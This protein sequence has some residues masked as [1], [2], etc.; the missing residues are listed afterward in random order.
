MRSGLRHLVTFLK[1]SG[2]WFFCQSWFAKLVHNNILGVVLPAIVGL[3]YLTLDVWGDKW[4]ILKDNLELHSRI[5][6]CVLVVTLC[7]LIWRAVA[8]MVRSARV[9][10][11]TRILERLLAVLGKIVKQKC[12][13]F[14]AKL[15]ELKPTTNPFDTITQPEEQIR[16]ILREA[17]HFFADMIGTQPEE[18]D[19]SV[20]RKDPYKDK[21]HFVAT[22]TTA[23]KPNTKPERLMGEKS[24]ARRCSE[25][26]EE[27]FIADKREGAANGDYFVSDKDR[28]HCEIGSAFCTPFWVVANPDNEAENQAFIVT[29]VTYGV[30][31]C[32]PFD[33]DAEECAKTLFREFVRRIEIECTL[34]ALKKWRAYH[35][36][37]GK[38]TPGTRKGGASN[39][40]GE[41]GTCEQQDNSE[42]EEASETDEA[43]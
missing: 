19:I 29:F 4:L 27:L 9:D 28:R 12:D 21:W 3:Y 20:M 22:T 7:V 8:D 1:A 5:Y 24:I 41:D 43:A 6:C 16:Y 11:Y 2:H 37:Q 39:E 42:Q 32:E 15:R 10:E 25:S 33:R 30:K 26:G 31:I 40:V 23:G 36:A 38:K 18:I 14:Q 17:Q 34:F 13:R 35:Q